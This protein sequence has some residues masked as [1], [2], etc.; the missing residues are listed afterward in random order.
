MA[1]SNYHSHSY[2]RLLNDYQ[3]KLTSCASLSSHLLDLHIDVAVDEWER[4]ACFLMRDLLNEISEGLPFPSEHDLIL[5]REVDRGLPP[6]S[7]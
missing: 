5:D 4:S 7:S 6:V 1:D 3:T 2:V